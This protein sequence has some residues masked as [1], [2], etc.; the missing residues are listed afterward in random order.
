MHLKR[1]WLVAI[2]AA[3]VLPSICVAQ[4]VYIPMTSLPGDGTTLQLSIANHD[5]VTRVFIGLVLEEGSD[6]TLQ[7]GE[8][9]GP[10]AVGAGKTRVVMGPPGI[11]LLQFQGSPLLRVSARLKT[12]DGSTQVRG[13]QVPVIDVTNLIPAGIPTEVAS[14]MS[15]PDFLGDFGL[16][17]LGGAETVCNAA[18]Y[19]SDGTQLG[20]SFGLL[21]SPLSFD[22]F[23][24]VPGGLAGGSPV[25][26]V[27]I[28]ISCDQNY[29]VFGRTVGL[30]PGYVG[31]NTPSSSLEDAF[32]LGSPGTTSGPDPDPE[33]EPPGPSGG[34]PTPATK[35][36]RFTRGGKFFTPSASRPLLTQNIGVPANR[37]YSE[38]FVSFEVKHGGWYSKQ[39]DGIHRIFSISRNGSFN[40]DTYA[41]TTARGPGK[42]VVTNAITIDLSKGV[43]SKKGTSA[44]L[45]KGVT[46]RVTYRYDAKA[47]IWRLTI[48]GGGKIKVDI[49][50][51]ITG[52]I[53]TLQ[54]KWEMKFSDPLFEIHVPSHGWDYSDLLFEL[55]P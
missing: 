27:R 50:K 7:E 13:A 22:F 41:F 30:A 34:G 54:G 36:F 48:S 28:E 42:N 44:S 46:Y 18:G 10:I 21:V 52:P 12:A 53:D 29:F 4:V 6:G 47:G 3:I 49:S 1:T 38:I 33:P 51:A 16:I 45:S 19:A 14:L 20:P 15:S 37:S 35:V 43:T 25:S 55:R 5:E 26:D 31:F 39:R 32:V 11:G 23:P 17:N 24:N 9:F 2:L 40:G 8:P